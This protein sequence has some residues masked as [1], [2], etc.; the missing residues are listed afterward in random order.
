M[1][2][3]LW[4]FCDIFWAVNMKIQTAPPQI[5]ASRTF[6]C[7]PDALIKGAQLSHELRRPLVLIATQVVNSL[8]SFWRGLQLVFIDAD[9][10]VLKTQQ[11][12]ESWWHPCPWSWGNP[13]STLPSANP[14]LWSQVSLSHSE[15]TLQTRGTCVCQCLRES[16]SFL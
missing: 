11:A 7:S 3:Y 12:G 2:K 4:I 10:L 16:V 13:A 15:H 6:I 9:T 14:R 8:N 1:N 5:I